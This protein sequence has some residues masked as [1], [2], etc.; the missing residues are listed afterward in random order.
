MPQFKKKV[1]LITGASSGIGEG[2]A[3]QFAKQG[4]QLV[5]AARRVENLQKLSDELTKQGVETLVC[6]CDV[7]FAGDCE[8]MVESAMQK[9]GKIDV[10]VANAGFG[11]VGK[12]ETLKPEDYRRQFET[13][14]YGVLNTLYASLNA[15]KAS[16]GRLALVGSVTGFVTLPG[17]SPYTMSKHAIRSLS[18]ALYYEL[19]SYGISVTHIAPGFV[20]SE[21]RRVDNLGNHHPQVQETLPKWIQMPTAKAAKK[22]VKAIYQRRRE[23]ILTGHGYWAVFAASHFPNLF[24]FLVGRVGLRAR[25][26]VQISK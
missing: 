23:R 12:F 4:A 10:V 25:K 2:L 3:K 24:A 15:L 6:R 21:I 9:F 16:K 5:L 22:I 11:V 20:T 19:K 26:Q 8:K 14:I 18:Y 17:N 13:N 7:T 1:V